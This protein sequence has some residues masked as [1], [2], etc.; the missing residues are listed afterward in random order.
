MLR[1]QIAHEVNMD[2]KSPEFLQLLASIPSEGHEAWSDDIPVEAGYKGLKLRKYHYYANKL[3]K[4]QNVNQYQ[5]STGSE[6][7]KDKQSDA[8]ALTAGSGPVIKVENPELLELQAKVKVLKSA[9]TRLASTTA[10]FKRKFHECDALNTT[11]GK[12]HKGA[13]QAVIMTL[14]NVLGSVLEAAAKASRAT[15]DQPAA[16][17]KKLAEVCLAAQT[18]AS[19]ALDAAALKKKS[20]AGYLQSLL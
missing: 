20:I 14:D 19:D 10:D 9:E 7:W 16:D 2:M 6:T 15:A 8:L 12:K 17:I 18:A 11:E 5:T 4:G 13:A 1:Y 3:T